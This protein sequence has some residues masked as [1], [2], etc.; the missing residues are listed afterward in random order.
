MGLVEGYLYVSP[1]E[2]AGKAEGRNSQGGG[3]KGE[4]ATSWSH[5]HQSSLA[6]GEGQWNGAGPRL[7]PGGQAGGEV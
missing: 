6:V 7:R 1:A 3:G 5:G 2:A 4:T